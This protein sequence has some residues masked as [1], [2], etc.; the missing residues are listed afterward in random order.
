MRGR[1]LRS[2]TEIAPAPTPPCVSIYQPTHRHAPDNQQDPIRF[3][4]LVDAA[5]ASLLAR[6][7][8]R[9]VEALLEPARTLQDDRDFW[10]HTLDGLAVFSAPGSFQVA[11]LQR[12]VPERSVVADSC[13]VKPLIRILQSADRFQVLS[14]SR[15]SV[16]LHEGNRDRLDPVALHPDVPRS[17]VDPMG[18]RVLS[19]REAPNLPETTSAAPVGG[20]ATD[21]D[22]ERFFRAVDRAVT[23]HH[24]GPSGPPLF[25]AALPESHDLF[26]RV[27]HNPAL[28]PAG[29]AIDP[30]AL[31]SDELRRHAW[32]AVRPQ[33]EARLTSLLERFG[34][35]RTRQLAS[36]DPAD[37]SRAAAA[38]RVGTLLLEAGRLLPGRLD[39]ATGAIEFDA[40]EDP[41][42]DDLLD[43]LAET[44]LARGGEVVVVPADRM[45]G[46]TGAAALY[47]F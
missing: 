42:V 12:S 7:P 16:A 32:D 19:R 9:D 13:H 15:D 46:P 40:L 14:L 1:L 20:V 17:R 26:R 45:P 28:Q 10:N 21:T 25:L 34:A 24:S 4:N 18:E 8:K 37:I 39:P 38:G 11:V 2:L 41:E 5:E 27:S 47:R 35:S 33:Y 22:A 44:V 30:F 36:S 31:D 29:I 3:R 6:H 23:A 43:D